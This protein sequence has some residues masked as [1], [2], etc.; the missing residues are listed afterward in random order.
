MGGVGGRGGDRVLL[1]APLGRLARGLLLLGAGLALLLAVAAMT[2]V[3]LPEAFAADQ[4]AA[5]QG[6]GRG[7]GSTA[8][9]L[10]ARLAAGWVLGVAQSYLYW[11]VPVFLLHRLCRI[12]RWRRCSRGSCLERGHGCPRRPIAWHRASRSAGSSLAFHLPGLA[13]PCACGLHVR[14]GGRRLAATSVQVVCG[15]HWQPTVRPAACRLPSAVCRL[16]S[17]VCRLPSAVC[18]L[19]CSRI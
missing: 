7:Y 11:C 17:A 1:Q 8:K 2:T 16:P 9:A 15:H 14:K 3:A 5:A 18:R 6:Q 13:C 12:P 10:V 4:T 19:P